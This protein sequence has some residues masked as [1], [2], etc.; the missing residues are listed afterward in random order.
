[1][2]PIRVIQYGL[3]PIGCET[4]KVLLNRKGVE[5]V[6]AVDIAPEKAG[7]DLGDLLGSEKLGLIVSAD[8]EP[9][10]AKTRAQVVTHTTRS[11]LK[12]VYDQLEAAARAGLSVVSSTEELLYPQLRSPDLAARLD[13]VARRYGATIL[14]TG[15][16]PGFVM[17]TLALVMTGVCRSVRRIRITRRVDAATRRLP[18]QRKVGAG[19]KPAEFRKLVREGKLGHIG[20][21]ESLHLV[22]TGLGWTL[23]KVTEKID[24]V[25]A[26]TRQVTSYFTVEPGEVCGIKHT[27]AGFCNGRRV[28]DLDLAMFIGAVEPADI[29]EIEGDPGLTV[30]IPGG[31]AGD[32]ATVAALVNAIP[33]VLGAEPGLKTV[34]DL[35][36]PRAF[37]V[38]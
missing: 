6:G 31:V 9:L 12:D 38:A 17:D 15:V 35:P 7:R 2:K 33:A 5:L 20:L 27:A 16:N 4:A 34:L 3:G 36:I 14:G 37:G 30:Q 26:E 23:S 10:F 24:P 21:L 25:L 28:I 29:I 1:M 18:L 22:S 13:R 8:P 32:V 11:F 19:M